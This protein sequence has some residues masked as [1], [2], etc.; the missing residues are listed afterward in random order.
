MLR[1]NFSRWISMSVVPLIMSAMD[2]GRKPKDWRRAM[3]A[4]AVASLRRWYC[5]LPSAQRAAAKSLQQLCGMDAKL[6]SGR[7]C[8][9]RVWISAAA[10]A[11]SRIRRRI[12]QIS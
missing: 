9:I 2:R 7:G 8:R 4:D 5:R 1:R 12:I 3:M 10:R 11:A 6:Q